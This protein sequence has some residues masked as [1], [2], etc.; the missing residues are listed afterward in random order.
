MFQT[1]ITPAMANEFEIV[2]QAIHDCLV[3]NGGLPFERMSPILKDAAQRNVKAVAGILKEHP[4]VGLKVVCF[5][6]EM[7]EEE[8]LE[9]SKGRA[10][11]VQAALRA[12]GCSNCIQAVGKGFVDSEGP[13]LDMIPCRPKEAMDFTPG[14]TKGGAAG[15]TQLPF[16]L[17]FN[18]AAIAERLSTLGDN[19]YDAATR[20]EAPSGNS[21][22]MSALHPGPPAGESASVQDNPLFASAFLFGKQGQEQHPQQQT[23]QPLQEPLW[24]SAWAGGGHGGAPVPSSIPQDFQR[25]RKPHYP[26]Y[27]IE[28]ID[29]T[30]DEGVLGPIRRSLH[31]H[32]GGVCF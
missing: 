18:A 17:P 23:L 2:K 6:G 31:A 3:A 8:A 16:S 30:E 11:A 25:P 26:G 27:H 13:R 4:D 12:E 28:D 32:C 14:V 22:T 5:T 1:Q 10:Q 29:V 9:L 21:S 20:R 19:L 24:P 15:A 7:K